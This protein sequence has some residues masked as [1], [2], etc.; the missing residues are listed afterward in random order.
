M[1]KTN[2]VAE[3]VLADPAIHDHQ[4]AIAQ[5]LNRLAT[6]YRNNHDDELLLAESR[7]VAMKSQK[8]SGRRRFDSSRRERA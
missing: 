1:K 2:E 3:Q 8:H 6:I 5:E 7:S 4:A